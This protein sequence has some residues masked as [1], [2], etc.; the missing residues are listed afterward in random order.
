MSQQTA[1]VEFIHRQGL[2][3][4][5]IAPLSALSLHLLRFQWCFY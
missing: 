2:L 3:A 5:L 4:L 1:A